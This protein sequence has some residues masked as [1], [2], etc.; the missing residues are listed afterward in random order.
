MHL[1]CAFPSSFEAPEYIA[2]AERLGYERAWLYDSPAIYP[3][4]WVTLAR[5][6]ERTE[7]IG[8]GP[9]VL[10]PSLRH[11]LVTASAI[12]TLAQLAEG[13]VNVAVGTGFT[14]R[15]MLGQKA[16]PW[17]VVRKYVQ[18][19]KALL[20]GEV[21]ELEGA[22][23]QMCHPEGYALKRPIEVP[24][25]IAANRPKG[26][27][28][29]R[30]VGDGVMITGEGG[31][32]PRD[33]SWCARLTFGTV[34]RPGETLHS[35]RVFEAIGPAIAVTYHAI[36]EARGALIDRFPGGAAWRQAIE[37]IPARERH[38]ALHAE[39]LVGINALDRAHIA[40]EMG[41][42]TFTGTVAELRTRAQE[43][44]ATGVTELMYAPHGPNI[45]D[46]LR[47]MRE[48]FA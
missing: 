43:L 36:Y 38:L 34:L 6:A 11:V 5:A 4:V 37:R 3:D 23:I 15:S 28:V 35:E 16:L 46:E 21:V 45:A 41:S 9:G 12:A 33:F 30:E 17:S 29:A 14:G 25:L 22:P 19:L 27:A 1:S 10:I 7:R 48:V 40:P 20:R 47:A 13:R 26:L 2:L 31:E 32:P 44:A 18:D 39:H 42:R 8:L 24:I